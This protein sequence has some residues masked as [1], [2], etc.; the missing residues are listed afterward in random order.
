VQGELALTAYEIASGGQSES[1]TENIKYVQG[2][3]AHIVHIPAP[4]AVTIQKEYC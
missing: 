3:L 2:D 4:E 1:D